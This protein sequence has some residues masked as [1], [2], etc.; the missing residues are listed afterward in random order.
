MTL[1]DFEAMRPQLEQSNRGRIDLVK[2]TSDAP[3]SFIVFFRLDS[4]SH[5][6]LADPRDWPIP[7]ALS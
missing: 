7:D 6:Q 3:D 1:D 5:V 2:R 4:G